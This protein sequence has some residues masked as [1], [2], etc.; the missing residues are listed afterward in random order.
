MLIKTRITT[1]PEVEQQNSRSRE[2]EVSIIDTNRFVDGT[3]ASFDVG[4]A[5]TLSELLDLQT[6]QAWIIALGA[7]LLHSETVCIVCNIKE[8]RFFPATNAN[9]I[10]ISNIRPY[11]KKI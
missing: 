11:F 8:S 5:R 1:S 6:R 4:S 3:A 9:S 10:L 7:E 2:Y